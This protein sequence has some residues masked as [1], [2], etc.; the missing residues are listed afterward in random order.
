MSVTVN[1]NIMKSANHASPCIRVVGLM[2]VLLSFLSAFPLWWNRLAGGERNLGRAFRWRK[3]TVHQ[4]HQA[5]DSS[6]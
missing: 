3:Q 1:T 6:R 2:D 5:R 4:R